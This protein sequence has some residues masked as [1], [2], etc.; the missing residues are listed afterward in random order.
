MS[1][2][3]VNKCDASIDTIKGLCR[4][5]YVNDG[6]MV[7]FGDKSKVDKY[8]FDRL[9]SIKIN[10]KRT[11]LI[12]TYNFDNDEYPSRIC[13]KCEKILHI[14]DKSKAVYKTMV[15]IYNILVFNWI[16]YSTK[17]SQDKLRVLKD[18]NDNLNQI[19]Y[20]PNGPMYNQAKQSYEQRADVQSQC[21]DPKY[22]PDYKTA[23]ICK[24]QE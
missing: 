16:E 3:K 6:V 12:F 4:I 22:I 8:S 23:G 11:K 21:R 17:Y 7:C 1:S 18:M 5:V 20:M 15:S 2:F 10:K 24:E 9:S 14:D 19:L 13:K